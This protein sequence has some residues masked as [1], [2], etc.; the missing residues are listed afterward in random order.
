M[1]VSVRDQKEG[2]TRCEMKIAQDLLRLLPSLGGKMVTVDPLQ[3]SIIAAKRS[4]TAGCWRSFV[5]GLFSSSVSFS[6]EAPN[7][8]A[9]TLNTILRQTAGAEGLF[10]HGE[11]P[12][13]GWN[14]TKLPGET[15]SFVA[16]RES[17]L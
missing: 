6:Y 4:K 1:L 14:H 3:I 5:M 7:K 2:T 16:V 17:I 15:T 12:S 10:R 11:W 13:S 8:A 9:S